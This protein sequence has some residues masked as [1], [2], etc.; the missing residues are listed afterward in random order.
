MAKVEALKYHTTAGKA[1]DVGDTYDV[2]DA[3]VENLSVQGMAIRV[4]RVAHA[5]ALQSKALKPSKSGKLKP[6]K[7]GKKASKSKGKK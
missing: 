4:D 1:Y 2:D 3:A 6:V 7:A 5:K